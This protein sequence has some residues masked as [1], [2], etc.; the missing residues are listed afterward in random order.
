MARLDKMVYFVF[1][2][3]ILVNGCSTKEFSIKKRLC[4]GNP[5]SSFLFNLIVEVL[6]GMFVKVKE[7]GLIRGVV[8]G[9]GIT[10]ISHL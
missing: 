2:M 8:F 1:S 4:Q 10:H 3:S 6:S 7:L 9:N 5:L